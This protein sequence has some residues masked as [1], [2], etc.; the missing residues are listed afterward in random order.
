M[1]TSMLA[2]CRGKRLVFP[3]ASTGTLGR[4]TWKQEGGKVTAHWSGESWEVALLMPS[5]NSGI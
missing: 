3:D 5:L 4:Y 2:F 1:L